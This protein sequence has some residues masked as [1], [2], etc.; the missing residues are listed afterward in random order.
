[1]PDKKGWKQKEN[2]RHYTSGKSAQVG[3][4]KN[5]PMKKT[6]VISKGQ[7]GQQNPKQP[8]Q[9]QNP[10]GA[11]GFGY[12]FPGRMASYPRGGGPIPVPEGTNAMIGPPPPTLPARPPE[13]LPIMD[14]PFRW[15]IRGLNWWENAKLWRTFEYKKS[16]RVH[17]K[18]EWCPSAISDESG[19]P[20]PDP[21][22]PKDFVYRKPTPEKSNPFLMQDVPVNLVKLLKNS[23]NADTELKYSRFKRI[24]PFSSEAQVPIK[25]WTKYPALYTF[26]D[27]SIVLMPEVSQWIGRFV[28]ASKTKDGIK[29]LIQDR[30][31]LQGVLWGF[32]AAAHEALHGVSRINQRMYDLPD[33]RGG[34]EAQLEEGMTDYFARQKVNRWCEQ[35]DAQHDT[36]DAFKS[37]YQNMLTRHGYY[38]QE[39]GVVM[40]LKKMFGEDW[41]RSLYISSHSDEKDSPKRQSKGWRMR[42]ISDALTYKFLRNVPPALAKRKEVRKMLKKQIWSYF[43]E[44]VTFSVPQSGE[45]G[46]NGFITKQLENTG[47]KDK[48]GNEYLAEFA[49]LSK[50]VSYMHSEKIDLGSAYWKGNSYTGQHSKA[51]SRASGSSFTPFESV[52]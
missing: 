33:E 47:V 36:G 18:L 16:G 24:K 51:N 1:M 5:Q 37:A 27:N 3:I 26:R 40:T 31:Q 7:S 4:Y 19:I 13:N 2:V 48:K 12:Q 14:A 43:H 21:L 15:R 23:F 22:T 30:T 32:K 9:Q 44:Y 45:G 41:I 35:A 46:T 34:S 38:N 28:Q 29:S 25:E 20:L 17:G 11:A 10:P 42:I 39:V 52:M 49:L 8:Q 6:L 50:F